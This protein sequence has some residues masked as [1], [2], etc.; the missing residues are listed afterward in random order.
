M[1]TCLHGNVLTSQ[2]KTALSVQSR[3][4][5]LDTRWYGGSQGSQELVQ[6]N[7]DTAYITQVCVKWGSWVAHIQVWFSN[8]DVSDQIGGDS[9][10]RRECALVPSGYC[11]KRVHGEEG[12]YIYGL[13]FFYTDS[14]QSDYLGYTDRGGIDFETSLSNT[15]CLRS[16][17]VNADK[18]YV[19]GI[20]FNFYS[21][22]P[23]PTSKPTPRPTPKPTPKP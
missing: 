23:K 22:T 15:H 11:I 14:T 16:L 5:F 18:D 13:Q 17:K 10:E 20:I 4:R 12:L 1:A 21:P 6:T 2:G 3:R 8:G 19:Y 7:D 9:G